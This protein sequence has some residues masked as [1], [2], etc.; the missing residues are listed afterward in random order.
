MIK[1]FGLKFGEGD[2][3]KKKLLFSKVGKQKLRC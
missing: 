3:R 2:R 1:G